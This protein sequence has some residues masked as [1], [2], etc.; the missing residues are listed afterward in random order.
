MSSKKYMKYIIRRLDMPPSIIEMFLA[1]LNRAYASGDVFVM[2]VVITN[3]HVEYI[4]SGTQNRRT[5]LRGDHSDTHRGVRLYC[6]DEEKAC[7][8]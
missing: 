1:N 6:F 4:S 3:L 8:L 5:F 2:E 7:G